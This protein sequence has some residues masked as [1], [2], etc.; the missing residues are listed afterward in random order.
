[1]PGPTSFTLDGRRIWLL[2][3]DDVRAWDEERALAEL[4]AAMDEPFQRAELVRLAE[5]LRAPSDDPRRVI[6]FLAAAIGRGSL[7][8]VR[9]RDPS[10]GTPIVLGRDEG[11]L[12]WDDIPR[13]SDLGT[14][15]PPWQPSQPVA[16]MSTWFELRIVDEL[17]QAIADVAIALT[18]D[19]ELRELQT[20]GDGRV[21]IDDAS[22]SFAT[23]RIGNAGLDDVL[24]ERWTQPRAQTWWVPDDAANTTIVRHGRQMASVALAGKTPHTVVV[25]PSLSRARIVGAGFDLDKTFLRPAALPHIQSVVALYGAHPGAALLVVGH[26]DTS[27]KSSVNDPLSLQRAQS[28]IAYLKDDVDAWLAWWDDG[29]PKS[30]RWGADEDTMMLDEV[31]LRRG[32]QPDG[33]RVAWFQSTRG[34]QV[35]GD[36]GPQTR[37]RIVTEY[38]ALDGTSLPSDITPI[39][40]GCGENFPLA[41]D[42]VELQ[43]DPP[44]G[45]SDPTD[46]RVELFFFDPPFGVL[47]PPPGANSPK[48]GVEYCEW[49]LRARQVDDFV[50]TRQLA[51]AVRVSDAATGAVI[52]GASVVLAQGEAMA[53]AGATATDA[54]GVSVFVDLVAGIYALEVRSDGYLAFSGA[55]ELL[56]DAAPTVVPVQLRANTVVKLRMELADPRGDAFAFPE[57]VPVTLVFEDGTEISA[58][59]DGDGVASFTTDRR[60]G[61]FT[62]RVEPGADA[63]FVATHDG[64]APTQR[65]D[66]AGAIA[67]AAKL[68][69]FLRVPARMDVSSPGRWVLD[70]FGFDDARFIS[71]R[72]AAAKTTSTGAIGLRLIPAWQVIALEFYDRWHRRIAWVPAPSKPDQPT[73]CLAG[74]TA[75]NSSDVDPPGVIAESVWPVQSVAGDVHCLAW[76]PEGDRTLP[77]AESMLRFV[78]APRTFVVSTN[79]TGVH[80]LEEVPSSGARADLVDKPS[81]QRLRFYDLPQDWRSVRQWARPRAALADD[82]RPWAELAAEPTSVDDPLVI[83][84]DDIVI[85]MGTSSFAPASL[86]AGEEPEHQLAILDE[87]MQVYRPNTTRPAG[88]GEPYFTDRQALRPSPATRSDM[89]LYLVLDH[90]PFTRAIVRHGEIHEVFDARIGVGQIP[91]PVGA[92][93]AVAWAPPLSPT[94]FRTPEFTREWP[95]AAVLDLPVPTLSTF[96]CGRSSIA[97]FRCCGRDGDGAER[98]A[99]LRRAR[100]FFDF[101]PTADPPA[102]ARKLAGKEVP[103]AEDAIRFASQALLV[104]SSRWNG[105]DRELPPMRSI[106]H[107]AAPAVA[108]PELSDAGV[109]IEV[110][111]PV[112]ARGRHVVLFQ[113]GPDQ[114]THEIIPVRLYE[115]VRASMPTSI[116]ETQWEPGDLEMLPPPPAPDDEE[117]QRRKRKSKR[118]EV[119]PPGFTTA[120]EL[121][122]ALTLPDEYNET[123]MHASMGAASISD[124]CR[125]PGAPYSSDHGS[126]MTDNQTPRARH[127]WSV[128]P[129]LVHDAKMFEGSPMTIVRGRARYTL[130]VT[131]QTQTPSH[132]PIAQSH[133]TAGTPVGKHGL[134]DV[135]MYR[136]GMDAFT[137]GKLYGSSVDKPYEAIVVARLKI[138]L[139]FTDRDFVWMQRVVLEIERRILAL[140][141]F[142]AEAE[143]TVGEEKL[144]TRLIVSPRIIVT[145]IPAP[146]ASEEQEMTIDDYLAALEYGIDA[147]GQTDPAHTISLKSMSNIRA[148]E[149]ELR[150]ID[151]DLPGADARAAALQHTIAAERT[152]LPSEYHDFVERVIAEEVVHCRVHVT[153]NGVTHWLDTD[154]TPRKGVLIMR[155]VP[156]DHGLHGELA[157]AGFFGQMLGLRTAGGLPPAFEYRPLFEALQVKHGRISIGELRD[158]R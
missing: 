122:H 142:A 106:L 129:W 97:V 78:T 140:S 110:G 35:D 6:D 57:D 28:V 66:R 46:R 61:R 10:V 114:T 153:R 25:Q 112:I 24:R 20:D 33:D 124:R 136:T 51:L 41:D 55:H 44:N 115:G 134:C 81:A 63:Y 56:A 17:A 16:P 123:K 39:A 54:F 27:G 60:D 59:T 72:E 98:F 32:E 105:D 156:A 148:A 58:S 69:R 152:K 103:S 93:A 4:R 89:P 22:T 30:H 75:S 107:P 100:L 131:E 113:R 52:R 146:A 45:A 91:A 139:S 73:L 126:M 21:R 36:L 19:G 42:G 65:T 150:E 82:K 151:L 31:L 158:P 48:A 109:E 120:H 37:R 50:V 11:T 70:P 77:D 154:S 40:H 87:R 137:A 147:R 85:A 12:D 119:P 133:T 3:A 95:F 128:V 67:A 96:G 145:S 118:R 15:V 80:D 7:R 74:H 86:I 101:Q 155:Q 43:V 143:V 2:S 90:P 29:V 76:F 68:H 108:P 13:L 71:L 53:G 34:L 104:S 79:E 38:M 149:R 94:F 26:T 117:K 132:F 116:D 121:G 14:D 157:I 64:S 127:F 125:S 62:V 47:P 144:R 92:R 23:A 84:L 8:I 5:L 88:I 135:F 83:S 130:P 102:G 99:V 49:L 138:A 1:M 9:L 141:D 111:D 18:V